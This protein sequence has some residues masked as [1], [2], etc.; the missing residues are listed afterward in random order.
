MIFYGGYMFNKALIS[1]V[2]MFFSIS[3][4]SSC[5][6]TTESTEA[7]S[8][9][10]G[11]TSDASTE[12]T[13]STSEKDEE[14]KEAARLLRYVRANFDRIRSDIAVGEGE[15]L[16]TLA[17]LLDVDQSKTSQFYQLSKNH[18]NELYPN[19]ETTPEQLVTHL[20]HITSHL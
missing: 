16:A 13:S 7:S 11:N 3:I 9:T 5:A 12:L 15:H 2:A 20:N 14:D 4:L 10:F 18:F 19:D 8:E 1:V 6:V 17:V